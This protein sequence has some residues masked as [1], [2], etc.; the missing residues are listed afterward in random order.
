MIRLP[1][2]PLC[3][4]VPLLL[5]TGCSSGGRAEGTPAVEQVEKALAA[6]ERE[7][8]GLS[9]RL[10][11][12]WA[13]V[14]RLP[15]APAG[16]HADLEA[17]LSKFRADFAGKW[18]ALDAP[19]TAAEQALATANG[20]LAEGLGT[21]RIHDTNER[22][23]RAWCGGDGCGGTCGARCAP[24]EV[25]FEGTCACVPQCDGKQCGLDGCGGFCGSNG[26]N[27]GDNQACGTDG[28]CT[29]LR[30]QEVACAPSCDLQGKPLNAGGRRLVREGVQFAAWQVRLGG[31]AVEEAGRL[32]AWLKALEGREA[33]LAQ[34]VKEYEALQGKAAEALTARDAAQAKAIE[35][36]AAQKAAVAAARAAKLKPAEAPDVAKANEALAQS[37]QALKTA[38]AALAQVNADL[39]RGRAQG[40]AW[41]KARERLKAEIRRLGAVSQQ[42]GTLQAAVD[43]A[44]KAL[45]EAVAERA[46]AR[47]ALLD[48]AR[49]EAEGLERAW[50]AAGQGMLRPGDEAWAG[51]GGDDCAV[52][53]LPRAVA[54]RADRT[55]A[56]CA[57]DAAVKELLSRLKA[58]A[59][60]RAE[61]KAARLGAEGTAQ[62]RAK[63]DR[64][65]SSA[66][67]VLLALEGPEA[68]RT[69]VLRAVATERTPE[70]GLSAGA[71]RALKELADGLG[72]GGHPAAPHLAEALAAAG[73][74]PS[75]SGLEA[76][77]QAL[78]G[79]AGTLERVLEGQRTW[80]HLAERLGALRGAL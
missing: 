21:V 41:T 13:E 15:E 80:A 39:L 4:L 43:S 69:A 62:A 38:A 24:S 16:A 74:V 47:T 58:A 59:S 40:E 35:A 8:G 46:R 71:A 7:L 53:S 51:C 67:Q 61:Q 18:E 57:D 14:R 19:V 23:A 73:E 30:E 31:S 27:C 72:A 10:A 68:K 37:M 55:G 42:A 78:L 54:C 20:R 63:L 52:A 22:M 76:E 32:A 50:V 44:T 25:C 26:G 11:Q 45:D 60:R 33:A 75:V 70:G 17:R 2:A 56:G 77:R 36:V 49:P 6:Q 29:P 1:R 9:E 66:I 28:K 12:A 48:A 3:L 64:A 79:L 5:V 34:Q 65:L